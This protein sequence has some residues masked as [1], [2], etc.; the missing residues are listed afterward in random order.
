VRRF[1]L[2]FFLVV[3]V[4]VPA[5]SAQLVSRT[6]GS[7]YLQFRHGAGVAKVRYK[8]NFFGHVTRGRIVATRNVTVSGYS[9][10]RVLASGLIE[11]RGPSSQATFMGFHTPQPPARWRVRL[12][13]RGIDASGFV[14]GC[15]VLNG[16]D[17]GPTGLF[18]IG[19]NGVFRAWPRAA[20]GYRLGVGC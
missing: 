7:V 6:P 20:T 16:V 5:A 2:V 4:A 18:K 19:Q 1:L 14:G 15:M 12:I 9:S 3:L 10:R 17:A 11:Y 8:G 13:G